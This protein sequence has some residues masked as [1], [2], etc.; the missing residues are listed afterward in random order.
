[1]CKM[2]KQTDYIQVKI[3]LTKAMLPHVPFDGWSFEALEQGAIDINFEQ[4]KNID[5]RMDIYRDLFKNGSIDFIEVFSEM[6]DM[7]VKNNYQLIDPKPERVPEKVKKIK[8]NTLIIAGSDD[9]GS[10]PNMSKN[11]NKDIQNSQYLE[12]KNGK[13]FTTIE[14]ADEVNN[15]IMKHLNNA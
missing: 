8:T 10:T 7:E 2:K 1:M 12:I 13:H 5:V 11:L 4:E 6:I 15:A 14:Y 9:T 3:D